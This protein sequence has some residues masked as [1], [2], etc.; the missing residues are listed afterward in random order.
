VTKKHF[1]DLAMRMHKLRLEINDGAWL[2][3]VHEMAAFC[4]ASN[5][6]FDAERFIKACER[7]AWK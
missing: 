2:R 6:R 1:E 7:E 3:V 4:R 5:P